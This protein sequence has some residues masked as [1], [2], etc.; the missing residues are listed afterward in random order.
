MCFAYKNIINT[1]GISV[2]IFGSSKE[3]C[4]GENI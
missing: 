1:L 2:V 4:N 3:I